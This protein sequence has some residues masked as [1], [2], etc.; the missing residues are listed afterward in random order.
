[1]LQ[2]PEWKQF[3]ICG[4]PKQKVGSQLM[5]GQHLCSQV[6]SQ[7]LARLILTLRELVAL[8]EVYANQMAAWYCNF[9][10]RRP[11]TEALWMSR[12]SSY[13]I[14]LAECSASFECVAVGV[15]PQ[16]SI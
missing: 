5:V 2:I 10:Y 16:Q 7:F 12:Y 1:M 11:S 3:C 15:L 6:C 8:H 4:S 14:Q 13:F 9:V